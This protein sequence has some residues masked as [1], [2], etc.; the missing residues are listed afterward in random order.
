MGSCIK[1]TNKGQPAAASHSS[2]SGKGFSITDNRQDKVAQLKT[3]I[4]NSSQTYNYGSGKVAVGSLMEAHLDPDDMHVGQSANLNTSQ[5]PMMTAI[6][7]YW[8]I[9]GGNVV[10]GHLLN[11]NLG[12]SA[13]NKNLYPITAAANKDH[14]MY[15]ENLV[16]EKV[17]SEET[18]IYYS[19]KV[20]G[21]PSYKE[22]Q[23]A[24]KTHVQDWNPKTKKY[25]AVH[26]QTVIPSDLTKVREYHQAVDA[27]DPSADLD[28]YS[29][30]DK[31]KWAKSPKTKVSELTADEIE[32][33]DSQT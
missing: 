17:W 1:K 16:K 6:R 32:E 30:P 19:L 21:K 27:D 15:V 3:T 4:K 5:N 9:K 8:N 33:R 20:D 18:G 24:F 12:G 28:T 23:A 25:G 10:K 31:P 26:G 14:L 2:S 22:S 7:K 11:D 29:N 13:L